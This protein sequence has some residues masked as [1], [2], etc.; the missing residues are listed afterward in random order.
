MG[1]TEISFIT[2]ILMV[3]AIA[4]CSKEELKENKSGLQGSGWILPEQ[5][6]SGGLNPFYLYDVPDYISVDKANHLDS[7][8][9]VLVYKSTNDVYVYPYHSMLVEV[10]NDV[11][12]NKY[13]AI[14]F[15]PLTRSGIAWNR[16][17]NN[18]TLLL[19][20]SGYLYKDNLMP[21]DVTSESIWSQ[22]L[23]IGA[24]GK[25]KRSRPSTFPLIE[26]HW[27]NIVE[28]F[29]DANVFYM[30][31]WKNSAIINDPDPDSSNGSSN[32][33]PDHERVLGIVGQWGVELFQFNLFRDSIKLY[34]ETFE[35]E[36]VMVIG[37]VENNFIVAFHQK[38]VMTPVQDEFPVIMQDNSGTKWNVFG[39]AVSGPNQGQQLTSPAS[40]MALG[41]A[42][43]DLFDRIEVF[44][45]NKN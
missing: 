11:I 35:K 18:D 38:Y 28:F 33:V 44:S 43:N 12:D 19:T 42:W 30:D 37:N 14:T 15:C 27:Q 40:Y 41:W 5:Y 45:T 9:L 26:T 25:F 16:L 20:A 32:Q 31:H 22:M 29:P 10:V 3:L 8:D 17:I 6:I 4:G 39:E 23:L 24:K 36:Q 7:N 1:K 2:L 21:F 13:L 34:T